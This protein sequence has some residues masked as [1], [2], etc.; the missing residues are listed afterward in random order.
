MFVIRGA[1]GVLQISRNGLRPVRRNFPTGADETG[2]MNTRFDALYRKLKTHLLEVQALET[3]LQDLRLRELR[4]VEIVQNK[5]SI[6]LKFRGRIINAKRN[7]HRGWN[8][9][10]KGKRIKTDVRSPIHDIRFKISQ[11]DI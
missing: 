5:S 2:N 6:T 11:G 8:L 10:E 9:T 3:E 4:K 1:C 7:M